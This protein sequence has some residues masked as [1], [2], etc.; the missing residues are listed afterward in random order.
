MNE[1]D[2]EKTVKSSDKKLSEKNKFQ[3]Q[4]SNLNKSVQDLIYL[5]FNRDSM[6]DQ[7]KEIGYDQN[8][9]PLGKLD[10]SHILKG[11]DVLKD[12]EQCLLKSRKED[13]LDLSRKYY[14]YIPHS[15]SFQKM[16][17]YYID[18]LGKLKKT[19]NNLESLSE[20]K[21]TNKILDV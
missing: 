21:I 11:F 13:I 16:K 6:M 4:R 15:F 3:K 9:I 5:I 14:S 17:N 20:I 10:K 2:D 19:L 7:I 1:I 12:I 8:K 18:N